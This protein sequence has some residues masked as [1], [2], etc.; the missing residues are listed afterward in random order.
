M[1]HVTSSTSSVRKLADWLGI[2]ASTACGIH[3]VLLPT[4]LVTG[5]IVPAS[6]LGDESFHRALLWLI[7]PAAIIAFGIGCWR[8]KDRWVLSLGI[9]G[10]IGIV[11][12]G[13]F[14][15]DI[16]G[17]TGERIATVVSAAILVAAHYRNYR[18]CR[19]TSCD[20]EPA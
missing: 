6:F 4:L 8:H 19:S 12:A 10:L 3:C 14:L 13:T 15:H 7:L 1:E 5:T 11:A 20:H 18:L 16:I 9:V 17:E 2:A